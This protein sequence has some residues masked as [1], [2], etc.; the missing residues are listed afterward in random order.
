MKEDYSERIKDIDIQADAKRTIEPFLKELRANL[1]EFGNFKV[2]FDRRINNNGLFII[3]RGTYSTQIIIMPVFNFLNG[4]GGFSGSPVAHIIIDKKNYY[5]GKILC[6]IFEHFG[7]G[8]YLMKD[9][10]DC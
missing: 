4:V 1:S 10:I 2:L 5:F 3:K 8:T 7:Y 9:Y 6:L